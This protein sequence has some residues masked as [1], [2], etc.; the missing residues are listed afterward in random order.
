MEYY[1]RSHSRW[2]DATVLKI[3]ASGDFML[4]VQ[5]VAPHDLVRPKSIKNGLVLKSEQFLL[6]EKFDNHVNATKAKQQGDKDG[7]QD[8]E[9]K[10][11]YLPDADGVFQ[12]GQIVEYFSVSLR[13]WI[14]A[15]VWSYDAV[16]R[17]YHLDCK[18]SGAP[19]DRVRQYL[20]PIKLQSGDA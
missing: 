3:L 13:Q 5:P 4:D 16:K 18:A 2:V 6:K 11:K 17:V 20:K 10:R 8:E 14:V 15:E 7:V 9:Y 19:R 1:S 12:Q